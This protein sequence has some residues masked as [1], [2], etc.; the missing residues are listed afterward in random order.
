MKTLRVFFLTV[1]SLVLI[2]TASTDVNA[3]CAMCQATV[4]SSL[5]GGDTTAKGINNG[6]LYLLAAPYLAIL[7][8]GILWY[9]KYRKKSI[10]IDIKPD[11][12]NLN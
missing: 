9:K 7:G 5:Q 2:L 4:E 11:E 10:T 12:I 1:L 6:I 8:I 3:Q